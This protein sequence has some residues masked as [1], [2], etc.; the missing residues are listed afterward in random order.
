MVACK[1]WV[2]AHA[3]DAARAREFTLT[4]RPAG[5]CKDQQSLPKMGDRGDETRDDTGVGAEAGAAAGGVGVDK[6]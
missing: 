4:W 5:R 6:F 1:P 2:T 3:S